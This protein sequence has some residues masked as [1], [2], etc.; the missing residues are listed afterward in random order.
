MNAKVSNARGNLSTKFVDPNSHNELTLSKLT[1]SPSI[2]PTRYQ[3]SNWFHCALLDQ[4]RQL[5]VKNGGKIDKK[6]AHACPTAC[7]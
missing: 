5:F 6:V 2:S 3:H 4:V 7:R 1:C